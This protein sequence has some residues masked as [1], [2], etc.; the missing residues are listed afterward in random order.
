MCPIK[1]IQRFFNQ[2]WRFIDAYWQGLIGRAAEWA[3]WKQ[4]AHRRVGQGMMMSIEAVLNR[5]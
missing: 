2:S 3:V 4:K 5:N 1:V